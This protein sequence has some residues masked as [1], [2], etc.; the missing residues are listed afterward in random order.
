VNN[1]LKAVTADDPEGANVWAKYRVQWTDWN[2]IR[3][4]AALA[5]AASFTLALCR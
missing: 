1:A 4:A 3:T 2:Q 5:A